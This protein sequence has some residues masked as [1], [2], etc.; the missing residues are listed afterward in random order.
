N[1]GPSTVDVLDISNPAN[2][3][4]I[5]SIDCTPFGGGGP[6]GA[7][8]SVAVHNGLLA[9]AVQNATKTNPGEVVFFDAGAAGFGVPLKT[10]TVGALPDMLCFTPDGKRVLV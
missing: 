2:P 10:V 5:T 9:I 8:N 4:L 6:G 1:A 7:P 3:T